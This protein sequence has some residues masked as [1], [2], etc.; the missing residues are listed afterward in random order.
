MAFARAPALAVDG[1]LDYTKPEHAKIFKS[2]IRPISDDPYDCEAGG[3]FQ[4]LKDIQDRSDEMG[5]TQGILVI[6]INP[7]DE[8]EQIGRA[9]V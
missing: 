5:W 2:G 7:G 6:T 9:H 1:I 8:G 3:L 4:F